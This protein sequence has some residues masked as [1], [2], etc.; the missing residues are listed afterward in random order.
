MTN[1]IFQQYDLTE[2]VT[3]GAIGHLE[4]GQIQY[5]IVGA[6]GVFKVSFSNYGIS[7]WKLEMFAEDWEKVIHLHNK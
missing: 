2:S 6:L 1:M 3:W 7:V 5:I 4:T